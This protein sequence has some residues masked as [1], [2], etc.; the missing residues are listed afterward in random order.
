MSKTT[1]PQMNRFIWSVEAFPI[2]ITKVRRKNEN[3]TRPGSCYVCNPDPVVSHECK[4]TY[5]RGI[6]RL[7]IRDHYLLD[8]RRQ[9]V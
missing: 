7:L 3:A 9:L 6:H 8:R 2:C 4:P 1:P 5:L